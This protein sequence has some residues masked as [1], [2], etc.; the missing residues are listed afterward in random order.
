MKALRGLAVTAGLVFASTAANAQGAPQ[1]AGAARYQATSDIAGPYADAPPPPPRVIYGA[2][3]YGP[4]AYGPQGYGSQGYG[5]QAYGAQ[6]YGQGYG[7]PSLLPPNEIYAVLRHN[8]FSPLGAP[9]LR[10]LFYSVSAIDREGEDGRLVIDG[11][12]GRIV[13]FVPAEHFGGFGGGYGSYG[14]GYYGAPPPRPSYSGPLEP[15][16]RLDGRPPFAASPKVASRLPATVPVPRAAPSR[17]AGEQPVA[18]KPAP[19]SV[20][21]QQSAAIQVKPTDTPPA[22]PAAPPVAAKP[23]PV[24]QAT[25]PMPRVQDLE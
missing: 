7:G 16:T 10:G 17:P 21:A 22:A 25:Q 11:R 8:G 9:R 12:D 1:Q 18:A 15:M 2:P 14:N 3:G 24:I 13:R 20:P 6:D 23:A 19:T 4:P 5:P